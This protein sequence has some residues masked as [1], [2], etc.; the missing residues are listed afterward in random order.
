MCTALHGCIDVAP[1]PLESNHHHDTLSSKL[2]NVHFT[3]RV[4][5]V[6]FTRQEVTRPQ[7]LS[8]RYNVTIEPLLVSV[9]ARS[10]VAR[11]QPVFSHRP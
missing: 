2:P 7:T 3:A 9:H 5:S 6:N 8:V 1:I 4:V 11:S 10:G